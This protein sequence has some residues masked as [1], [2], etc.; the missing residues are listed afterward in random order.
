[1]R[2]DTI[3]KRVR[4]DWLQLQ[5]HLMERGMTVGKAAT[6]WHSLMGRSVY[7]D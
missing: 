6:S 1:V 4:K 2:E 5:E 3:Y 7:E